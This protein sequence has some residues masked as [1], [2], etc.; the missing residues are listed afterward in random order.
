MN[1]QPQ[2]TGTNVTPPT[3]PVPIPVAPAP[4]VKTGITAKIY[5][6]IPQNLKDSLSKFYSNKKLF[7]PVAA[8]LTLLFLTILIGLI[9]GSRGN[10][11]AAVKK[12][13]TPTPVAQESAAPGAEEGDKETKLKS[14]RD[15]IN[16]LDVAQK[17]L[18]PPSVNFK[19]DF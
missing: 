1:D 13:A 7:I 11:T 16:T 17:R 14:L 2:N 8:A 3:P 5:A 9:F 12:T 18:S 4:E 6:K 19:I 10:R 15:Q